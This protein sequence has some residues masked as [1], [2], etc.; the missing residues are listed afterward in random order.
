[1]HYAPKCKNPRSA[2]TPTAHRAARCILIF[3]RGRQMILNRK[4]AGTPRIAAA[5]NFLV[6]LSFLGDASPVCFQ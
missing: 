3:G 6:F 5:P 4:L 1:M 2:R